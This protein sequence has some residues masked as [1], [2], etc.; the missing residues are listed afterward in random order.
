MSGVP[1]VQFFVC[2]AALW[3]Q[4]T[5]VAERL[6]PG[7]AAL[8]DALD[9]AGLGVWSLDDDVLDRLVARCAEG[10]EAGEL[11]LAA[12]RPGRFTLEIAPDGLQ[13]WVDVVPSCGGEPLASETILLVLGEAGVTHGL[14]AAAIEQACRARQRGRFVVARGE[15][16]VDGEP[17]RFELLVAEARD[18]TPQVNERGLIDFREQGA[19]PTVEAEQALMRRIPAT[20][21]TPGRNVRGETLEPTPGHNAPFAERLVGAYVAPDDAN[22]LRAV[23]SGQPVCLPD[24]V[25]VEH[26]LRVR[27][28]NLASGNISFDGTVQVEGEVMPDMKIRATGDVIV[29]GLIDGA[30]VEAGGDVRVAGGIIAKAR[31]VA[32]GTIAARFAESALLAAGTNI[33]IEDSALQSELQANNQILIGTKATQRGRLA[34]GSARAMMLI[35]TPLLGSNKGGVTRLLLGVN[36]VLEAEYQALLQRLEA[37]KAEEDKLDKIVKHLSTQGDPRGLLPRAKESWQRAL[38]AWAQLMPEREALER[39]LDLVAG[40]RVEVSVGVEGAVD[41]AFGKKTLSVRYGYDAGFFCV[42]GGQVVFGS[43]EKRD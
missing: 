17:S 23:F 8:Q 40:A 32:G 18:R 19:I 36:P 22:L 9:A 39:R 33:V 2:D 43:G 37:Q 30:D 1:G 5:P 20:R 12:A 42:E 34:G 14:D 28:V 15:P 10:F 7:R 4:V 41:L 6:P 26:V 21:G 27:N 3:A 16:A 25:S 31:V 24:G 29:G 13:A 38:Q 11:M 35:R